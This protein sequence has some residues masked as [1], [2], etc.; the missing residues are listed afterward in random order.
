MQHFVPCSVLNGWQLVWPAAGQ[1]QLQGWC[2]DDP[3]GWQ[4]RGAPVLPT[5][6]G[7]RPGGGHRQSGRRVGSGVRLLCEHSQQLATLVVSSAVCRVC[8]QEEAASLAC[9]KRCSLVVYC[10]C[11]KALSSI[12]A[13]RSL[14]YKLTHSYSGSVCASAPGAG[15]CVL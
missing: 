10:A 15:C 9:A 5:R 3:H 14:V 4:Q 11:S 12:I 6:Y 1:D 13:I 7:V 8:A 2:D